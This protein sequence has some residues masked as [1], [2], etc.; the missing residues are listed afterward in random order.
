MDLIQVESAAEAAAQTAA[1]F[2]QRLHETLSNREYFVAAVS[3]G[4]TPAMMFDELA[5]RD[6]P[7][8]QIRLT[9]VDERVAP[10]GDSA[11][12]LTQLKEHL[13]DKIVIPDE[14][15]LPLP[16]EA[17][18]L[19][20]ACVDH[21]R[22]LEVLAGDGLRFD[23]IHLG[24]GADGHTASLVPN[25]PVLNVSDAAVALTGEYQGRRRLTLTFPVLDQAGMVVWLVTGEDK[26]EALERMLARDAAIPAGRVQAKKQIVVADRAATGRS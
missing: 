5:T 11:R 4:R 2:E 1:L 12:N 21:A 14:N 23:F 6:L 18:D 10:A 25:D 9:Q 20:E 7:W 16:V 17:S 15:V 13:L 24:L 3:G 19:T 22:A 26:V 8:Q